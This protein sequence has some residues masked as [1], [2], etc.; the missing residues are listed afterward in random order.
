MYLWDWFIIIHLI[1]V[2]QKYIVY[3]YIEAIT[4]WHE[5]ILFS[6][7]QQEKIIFIFKL[8]CDVLF[9]IWSEVKTS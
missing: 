5:D 8:L 2:M 7:F 1:C 6:S 3:T 9:I 4:Q